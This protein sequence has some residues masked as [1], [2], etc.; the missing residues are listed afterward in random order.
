MHRRRARS[1]ST[2]PSA[3]LREAQ[4]QELGAPQTCLRTARPFR[5]R[6]WPRPRCSGDRTVQKETSCQAREPRCGRQA[7]RA[8]TNIFGGRWGLGKLIAKARLIIPCPR[9]ERLAGLGETDRI[10]ADSGTAD[11]A[12]VS[13]RHSSASCGQASRRG[14]RECN[15]TLAAETRLRC[16]G[17]PIPRVRWVWR[18]L[19]L[20]S[21]SPIGRASCPAVR[22][23]FSRVAVQPGKFQA[24]VWRARDLD[25]L[26]CFRETDIPR[27]SAPAPPSSSP[28]VAC[29]RS[30]AR[31][32]KAGGCRTKTSTSG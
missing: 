23:T 22:S 21:S 19:C 13:R 2:K 12:E 32:G 16:R 15:H 6:S 8:S 1:S 29:G 25:I 14:H 28:F 20:T 18:G 11:P 17:W 4:R 10:G 24:S 7:P 9:R 5:Y 3:N 26:R 30:P 31:R 27:A